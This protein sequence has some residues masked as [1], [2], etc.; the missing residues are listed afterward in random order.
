MLQS[1]LR[2]QF[3][4]LNKEIAF[5]ENAGTSQVP[6]QL[7]NSL[8][9]YLTESYVQ[10]GAPYEI[11]QAATQ[12]VDHGH[13]FTEEVFGGQGKGKAILGPSST[14]L[15]TTL[16]EA[17]RK[18]LPTG[19]T[20]VLAET[21]HE[22]NVGPWLKLAEFGFHMEFWKVNPET[23]QCDLSEL[24]A[25]L[26]SKNVSLVTLPHVSNLLGEI[27]DVPAITALAHEHGA[28]VVVD[29]VAFAPHAPMQV[30]DWNV[31]WYVFSLYKVYGPHMAALWG[32]HEELSKLEG[33]NHFFIPNSQMPY[34][35]QLGGANHE[36]TAAWLGLKDYFSLAGPTVQ[37]AFATFRQLE[38]PAQESLMFFLESIP[39]IRLIGP[40]HSENRVPTI[41]FVHKSIRS[42]EIAQSVCDSGVA[43]RNGHM[44][45]YRL[46]EALGISVEDGVVRASLV[47]YNTLEEVERFKGALTKA[48]G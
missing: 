45:A 15:L 29:G 33:P 42:A 44:Y 3:P 13:A 39:E 5:F 9:Q 31:D 27:V 41:S 17:Y 48:L 32:T 10:L 46:C 6:I 11:S 43:V 38:L 1:T 2:S 19:S 37:D 22:A 25:I 40:K 34:K 28:K 47:H 36:L 21:G 16:A 7:I 4:S 35:F 18:V 20:I 24:E 23:M 8:N 26:K 14:Q 30:A 12:T